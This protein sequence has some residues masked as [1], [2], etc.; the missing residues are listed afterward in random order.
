MKK[1]GLF[2]LL[3]ALC[4]L[5]SC[6]KIS[7]GREEPDDGRDNP[8]VHPEQQEDTLAFHSDSLSVFGNGEGFVVLYPK[9]EQSV[10]EG[11]VLTFTFPS[12]QDEETP[13]PCVGEAFEAD[14]AQ[15]EVRLEPVYCTVCIPLCG[16]KHKLSAIEVNG[17]NYETIGGRCSVSE[18]RSPYPAMHSANGAKVI[19]KELARDIVLSSEPVIVKLM[20]PAITFQKG[21]HVT[22]IDNRERILA[23]MDCSTIGT[24][25]SPLTAGEERYTDTLT[26]K[27]YMIEWSTGCLIVENGEWRFSDTDSEN[28]TEP[29]G[30][31]F[32]YGAARGVAIAMDTPTPGSDLDGAGWLDYGALT[33][34]DLCANVDVPPGENHWRLPTEE[35][36]R[37][38]VMISYNNRITLE[39]YTNPTVYAEFTAGPQTIKVFPSGYT[40]SKGLLTNSDWAGFWVQPDD[41]YLDSERLKFVLY[42]PS[43]KKVDTNPNWN[44]CTAS[45]Y[46]IV[47]SGSKYRT[48]G[49]MY[50]CCRDK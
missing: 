5:P 38:W 32:Q 30:M 46:K 12:I 43:Y 19:R 26:C 27:D 45:S 44:T 39:G 8:P 23:G 48:P 13:G 49:M 16:N 14:S 18:F 42:K 11:S 17:L 35:E 6:D 50:R 24:L 10:Y 29:Y 22:A 28:P 31:I 47:S 1:F 2:L 40:A 34:G 15:Y 20:I 36:M 41:D 25:S 7:A 3:Y 37:D 33:Q 21:I 9:E 4:I